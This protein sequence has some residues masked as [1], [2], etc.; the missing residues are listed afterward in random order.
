M[1][2]DPLERLGRTIEEWFADE[3]PLRPP[4]PITRRE[5]LLVTAII[6]AALVWLATVGRLMGYY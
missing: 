5:K 4:T 1:F 3:P 6:V 2:D